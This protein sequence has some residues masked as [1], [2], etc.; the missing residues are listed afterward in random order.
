[1]ETIAFLL[2][3][4]ANANVADN[5][6]L[7]PIVELVME[8]DVRGVRLLLKHSNLSITTK[9]GV[10]VF[11]ISVET[12]S[13]DCFKLLLPR[14]AD[15]DMRTVPAS[16]ENVVTGQAETFNQTAAHLACMKGQHK[17][18]EKLLRRSASRMA[19]DSTK[20]TPL[21][22]AAFGHLSCI[23]QLIGHPE[24]YKMAPAD[25]NATDVNGMTPLH[26]AA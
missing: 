6:G 7:T 15:V 9:Q 14:M 21:H 18:L 8:K 2:D 1:V 25:I 17:V 16:L 22:Y 4:G 11:H 19:R 3:R 24:A 13:Y 12:S 10:N 23:V 5:H 26:R 20:S